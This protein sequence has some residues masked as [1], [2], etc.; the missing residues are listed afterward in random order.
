MPRANNATGRVDDNMRQLSFLKKVFLRRL[1][2]S[3]GRIEVDGTFDH[4]ECDELVQDGLI[5]RHPAGLAT[6]FYAITEKG[7]NSL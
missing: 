2:E 3:G 1:I 4:R 5:E 6:N 7:R